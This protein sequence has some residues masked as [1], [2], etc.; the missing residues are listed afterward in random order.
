MKTQVVRSY[1]CTS[2]LVVGASLVLM[3]SGCDDGG[4]GGSSS[5][6]AR[7][8]THDNVVLRDRLGFP[9]AAGSEEPYSPRETCGQCHWV[10]HIA[11]GYHFQQGRTDAAGAMNVKDD[12]FGKGTDYVRSD[13]MYGKW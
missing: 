1:P 9:I 10:D 11:N 3:I 6:S 7:V 5:S 4:G 8:A 13:G 2:A 12:Y